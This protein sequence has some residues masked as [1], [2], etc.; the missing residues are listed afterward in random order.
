MESNSTD[1][2]DKSGSDKNASSQPDHSKC[3][4]L[5]HL[6]L[7]DEATPEEKEYFEKHVC[8]CMPYYEIYHVD[9]AIKTLVKKSCCGENVP[10]D[11]AAEIKAKL[12]Q[13]AD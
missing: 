4:K 6:V 1:S 10:Q 5:L 11:L 3:L 7:D 2:F 12:F 9:K 8:N 13:R